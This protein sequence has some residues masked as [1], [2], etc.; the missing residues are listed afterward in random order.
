MRLDELFVLRF[1]GLFLIFSVRGN[2]SG[3]LA[4]LTGSVVPGAEC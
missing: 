3:E 4:A 1:S 2:G